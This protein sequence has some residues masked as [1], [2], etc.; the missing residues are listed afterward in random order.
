M[1]MVDDRRSRLNPH[2]P[3]FI[4]NASFSEVEDFSPEWWDLVKTSP[5]FRDYWLSQRQ[6][7]D[8]VS[9]D[10]YDDCSELELLD[11]DDCAEFV[12]FKEKT[13]SAPKKGLEPLNGM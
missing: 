2:A 1:A 7:D 9:F 11:M 10:G 4:P 13:E 6:E 3:V 8:F 12:E 5:W